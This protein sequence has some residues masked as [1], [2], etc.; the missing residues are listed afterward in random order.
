MKQREIAKSAN[1]FSTNKNECATKNAGTS[2]SNTVHIGGKGTFHST[3][4][5]DE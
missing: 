3:V 5:K 2:G 4:K 1:D